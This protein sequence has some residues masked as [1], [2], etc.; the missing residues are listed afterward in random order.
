M[1]AIST[2]ALY[3][4]ILARLRSNVPSLADNRIYLS[5]E[6]RDPDVTADRMIGVV[7]GDGE[8]LMHLSGVLLIRERFKVRSRTRNMADEGGRADQRVASPTRGALKFAHSVRVALNQWHDTAVLVA[9]CLLVGPG[10]PKEDDEEEG[11]IVVD[12]EYELD[13]ELSAS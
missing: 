3:A 10:K 13:Y 2:D 11:W 5:T 6:G 8:M 12:D 1:A 7:T 4:A 9:P